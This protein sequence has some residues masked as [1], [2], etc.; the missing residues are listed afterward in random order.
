MA[1]LSLPV[2]KPALAVKCLVV[3]AHGQKRR[4]AVE[5]CPAITAEPADGVDRHRCESFEDGE[6]VRALVWHAAACAADLDQGIHVVVGKGEHT[7]RAVILEGAAEGAYTRG[8]ERTR[9]RIAVEALIR[10][11]FE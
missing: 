9:Q 5:A 8:H 11:A 4:Q 1:D 6:C 10:L 7:A 3:K 2:R